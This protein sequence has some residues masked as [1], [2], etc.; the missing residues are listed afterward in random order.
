ML[1]SIAGELKVQCG[2]EAKAYA[3]EVQ[4]IKA[5]MHVSGELEAADHETKIDR[6]LHT[7]MMNKCGRF[8]Y[9]EQSPW[10]QNRTIKD[11]ILFVND[12]EEDKYR[13]AIRICELE[14]DLNILPA[15][16]ATEIGERGINLSGGQKARVSLARAI[17]SDREIYLLDDPL[18][19]L[20][21]AVKN[22]IFY[23]CIIGRLGGKTRILASHC[24]EYL[25][26]A[27]RIVVLA[28][29]QI[30]FD[31]QYPDFIKRKKFAALMEK[32]HVGGKKEQSDLNTT[33]VAEPAASKDD[34]SS[35]R[36]E[37][38]IISE[39]DQETGRVSFAVYVR[40][41]KTLGGVVFVCLLTLVMICW[42]LSTV[43]ADYWLGLW[44]KSKL[45]DSTGYFYLLGNMFMA[46]A[47]VVCI[48]FRVLLTFK[49]SIRASTKLHQTILGRL[50][51]APVTTFF[52]TT[53]VGRILNRLSNDLSSVDME[54]P[55]MIGNLLMSLWKLVGFMVI[56]VILIYWCII[57][58]PFVVL[59]SWYYAK[60]YLP[61]Q[62]NLNRI[63]KRAKSPIL[64]YASET[65]AGCATIRAYE[66]QRHF[67]DRCYHLQDTLLKCDSHVT[68][69]ECWVTLRIQL[70][71]TA[72]NVL[73]VFFV[74][75]KRDTIS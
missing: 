55:F 8:A 21:S 36:S 48:M 17:Y 42:T 74:V 58:L 34:T 70:V 30:V 33:V 52:H 39:E 2:E 57:P 24:I 73:T 75:N 61:L 5:R 1:Q 65:Y 71:S 23:N 68:A 3:E 49:Y 25:D 7:M 41:L 28:K 45:N 19:A 53:P 26:K 11:N 51:R 6:E 44:G 9:V 43:G 56:T 27:D 63:E 66:A 59:G 10:I 32:I 50:M 47:A 37:S 12:F 15:G 4:G 62:R 31:G 67:I 69:L 72:M 22:K 46:L 13:E 29:G 16:D 14:E 60:Q 54:M 18:S 64:Q 40:Y 20:D 38:K 35:S